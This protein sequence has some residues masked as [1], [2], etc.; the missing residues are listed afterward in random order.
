MVFGYS[1]VVSSCYI[2]WE[3]S[4]V[5]IILVWEFIGVLFKFNFI[6][7]CCNRRYFFINNILVVINW[8]NK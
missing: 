4:W 1:L 3:D 8:F 6:V 7:C 2:L 5:I